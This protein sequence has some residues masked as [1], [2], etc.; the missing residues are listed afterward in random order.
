MIL[1][2]KESKELLT[3]CCYKR[4]VDI[5]CVESLNYLFYNCSSLNTLNLENFNIR[6][7]HRITN[8]FTGCNNLFF[9]NIISDGISKTDIYNLFRRDKL[10]EYSYYSRY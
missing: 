4:F 5:S 7:I 3:V 2:W 6:N 10:N 9:K 1:M 8:I